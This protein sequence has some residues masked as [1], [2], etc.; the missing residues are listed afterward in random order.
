M[1]R[2]WNKAWETDQGKPQRRT[3]DCRSRP[4]QTNYWAEQ[5]RQFRTSQDQDHDMK[6]T[7]QGHCCGMVLVIA[8]AGKNQRPEGVRAGR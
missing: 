8:H 3:N 5:R 1:S 4:E 2:K 6:R 7:M